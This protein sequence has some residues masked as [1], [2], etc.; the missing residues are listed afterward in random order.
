MMQNTTVKCRLEIR[1]V[2]CIRIVE[3]LKPCSDM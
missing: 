2:V 3:V 1:N